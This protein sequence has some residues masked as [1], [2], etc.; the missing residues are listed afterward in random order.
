MSTLNN[1]A[2]VHFSRQGAAGSIAQ[3]ALFAAAAGLTAMMWL[4]AFGAGTAPRGY[5]AAMMAKAPARVELPRVEIIS[6]RSQLANV[7][8][9]EV[10][11]CAVDRTHKPG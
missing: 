10:A 4:S 3:A 5:V 8:A 1:T 11:G 6:S 7:D 2:S 9:S